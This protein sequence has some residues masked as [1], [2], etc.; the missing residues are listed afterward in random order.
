MTDQP[1]VWRV[2]I[3]D[4]DHPLHQV[5][6]T[7]FSPKM[8]ADKAA[9][10]LEARKD[11]AIPFLLLIL[12]NEELAEEGSLGDGMAPVHAIDLLAT[13]RVED[14][15]PHLFDILV[16]EVHRENTTIMWDRTVL[17][18]P[19]YGPQIVPRLLKLAD[20]DPDEAALYLSLAADAKPGHAEVYPRAQA[21]FEKAVKNQVYWDVDYLASTLF[22]A[23]R[24]QTIPYLQAF[25]KKHKMHRDIRAVIEERL[26]DELEKPS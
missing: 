9:K 17:V 20:E 14:A 3:K 8:K 10:R 23:D 1:P 4:S 16:D 26:K 19:Y 6:W 5:A 25:L 13:W 24:E 11:E 22:T 21:E 7:V 2:A 15:L 12:Q 18:L